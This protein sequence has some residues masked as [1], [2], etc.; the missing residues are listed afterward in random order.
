MFRKDFPLIINNPDI[1]YLDNAAT[2]QKPA[3]V[4]DWVSEFL[5]SEYANVHRWLYSLSEKSETHYE[6]SKELVSE[7]L[8]CESKEVIYAA[9]AT[10]S[11][12][13]IAQTLVNSYRLKK[14][15][16]VLIWI[17]DHHA[18]ILPRMSLSKLFWFN[19]KFFWI[20]ED[21]TIDYSDFAKKYTDDVKVVSCWY[22]SNV[23]WAIYDVKK[24]KSLLRD[25]TFYIVDAS[26]AVPNLLV[27]FQE[28]WCDAL[29]FTAHKIMA[30]T[31]VWGLILK[32]D[33]LKQLQPLS[34]WWWTVK[35]VSIDEFKLKSWTWKFESWTPDIIWAVSLEYALEYVK[36]LWKGD[37]KSWMKVI[38]EH[39]K[40][41]AEYWIK[42]FEE[43]KD[44]LLLVWP[45][46]NRLPIF[47][48]IINWHENYNQIGEYF[49]ERWICIR[50]WWHCA[51][52]L[53]KSLDIWWS[54]RMSTYIYNDKEDIDKFFNVL[55]ELI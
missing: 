22:V 51:Y 16:S 6:H 39:E 17:R 25:D 9:N 47:S 30:F 50:C 29:V 46:V 27:D 52:P 13:L 35:D 36:S 54:C 34:V 2:T 20:N 44:N 53:Y 55:N 7:L 23:T 33:L 40:S 1:L 8:N 37:M 45:K 31:W 21:Y 41:M 32:R 28:I 24:I 11:V 18:N 3:V 49:A 19:V 14:G 42:K 38:E 10:A 48:F 12:N 5:K 15:D 43:L 26:Q 4:I